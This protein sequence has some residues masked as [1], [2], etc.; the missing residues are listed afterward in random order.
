MKHDDMILDLLARSGWTP[1]DEV[2]EDGA[3]ICKPTE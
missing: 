3:V 2:D 1:T